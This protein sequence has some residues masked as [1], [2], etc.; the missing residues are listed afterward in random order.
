MHASVMS[1]KVDMSNQ[2]LHLLSCDH[3][4]FCLPYLY[5]NESIRDLSFCCCAVRHHWSY[6]LTVTFIVARNV[7]IDP[8]HMSEDQFL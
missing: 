6:I 7:M 1:D 3:F 8:I 2:I 4:F 5:W